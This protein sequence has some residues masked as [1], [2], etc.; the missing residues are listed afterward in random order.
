VTEHNS[1]RETQ[2]RTGAAGLCREERHKDLLSVDPSQSGTVVNDVDEALT[3]LD[4]A[5]DA[6]LWLRLVGTCIGGVA[7]QVNR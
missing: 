5:A 2:S 4:A 7:Q 6:N 1:P 3:A